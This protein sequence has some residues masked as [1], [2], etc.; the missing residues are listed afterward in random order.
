VTA[1]APLSAAQE[2]R[3]AAVLGRVYGRAIG[4][5]ITIDPAV[6]GGLVIRVGDEIID[7]SVLRRLDEA[8]RRL[9]G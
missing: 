2:Q 8:G 9:V 7:G 6:L 4:L 1:A 5:Q 3:L